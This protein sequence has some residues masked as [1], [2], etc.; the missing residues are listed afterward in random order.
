MSSLSRKYA[1]VYLDIKVFEID[2]PFDYEIPSHIVNDVEVGSV[3]LVPFRS[4][5][6]IGYVVKIKDET[7]VPQKEIKKIERVVAH[8]H[9]LS[10]DRLKLIHWISFYYVQPFGKVFELFLPPGR[11]NY[12]RAFAENRLSCPEIG[13]KY[14]D[15]L[16]LNMEEY[17]GIKHKINWD[18]NPSKKKIIQYLMERNKEV[19]REELVKNLKVSYSTLKSLVDQKILDKK[20]LRVRRDF[21]YDYISNEKHNQGNKI[22]LNYYQRKCVESITSFI[23]SNIFHSFLIEGVTGSGKTEIYIELCRK[24][25]SNKKRALVLTPEISLIP[26]LF[27][28]FESEFGLGVKVYHSGMSEQ[29]RYE[30]WMDILE[31]DANIV[32]GTRSALFTPINDLGIIIVDE[33]HDPSYK[34][35]SSV[36]YNAQDV[37]LR[38][39]K[40]LKIPV[41]LGSATPSVVTKYRAEN[42]RDSTLLT[43]PIKACSN[44]LV[45]K[46]VVDLKL[47]DKFRDDLIITSKLFKAIN[48]EI[49][50]N[51]RVIIF[52]NRRGY[53]NFVVCKD[54]GDIPKCANCNLSYNF[55]RDILKLVCHHCGKEEKFTGRCLKCGSSNILLQGTGIQKVE[56]RLKMYF[57]NIPVIR[58][59]S[60][61]TIK[62]K[63]HEQIL[64]KFILTRPS[65]LIGTQMIAKGL[66][67][68]DIT[69]VGIINCDSMLALPDFHM[70]ERVYQLI[71]QVSG[72]TGRRNKEGKVIIQTYNPDSEVIKNFM[73]GDYDRFYKLELRNREELLYPPFSNLINIVI[74]GKDE[75]RVREDAMFLYHKL[76]DIINSKDVILGPAPCPFSKINLFFRWHILI[77]TIKIGRLNVKLG[78]LWR[79]I[80]KLESKIIIDVDP[81]WIL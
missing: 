79:R 19:S 47:I 29:E 37:A 52:I 2:H 9:I 45:H 71:T 59:D 41:V 38:W 32:I 22:C 1:E 56:S 25:L 27:S 81:T 63:S 73:E 58:M 16:S 14:R 66:D 49:K 69:L 61:I 53:S 46:E 28:K 36:R 44:S 10:K 78:K 75:K 42:K 11:K 7:T 3:V 77:K 24:V 74:S 31:G 48:D 64:K 51:N 67:I 6:I 20:T 57:K 13:F 33:E 23:G 26:Q 72:R 70:N 80:E 17:N 5:T 8:K 50:N 21:R 54:C 15:F 12:R 76:T 35:S 68:E 43:I 30:R 40:I 39:G 62:K 34:E 60:D 55:H 4:R 65:I 18:R